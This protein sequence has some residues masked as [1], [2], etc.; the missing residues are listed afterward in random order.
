MYR[1]EIYFDIMVLRIYIY[2]YI[3]IYMNGTVSYVGGCVIKAT[4]GLDF[5]K[6]FHVSYTIMC[7]TVT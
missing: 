4:M 5:K 1:F 3:Y 2:T 7:T 6:F